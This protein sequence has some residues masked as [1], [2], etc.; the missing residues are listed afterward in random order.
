[1]TFTN[2]SALSS[3]DTHPILEVRDL[4]KSY[5]DK[6]VLKGVNFDVAPSEVITFIGESGAGKSTMLRCLNLLEEPQGRRHPLSRQVH[7]S[8]RL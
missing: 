7:L 2:Q 5:G 4:T 1:M 6:E 3:S 8:S